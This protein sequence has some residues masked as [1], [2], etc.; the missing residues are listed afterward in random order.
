MAAAG[1][2]STTR[3]AAWS[4]LRK[5]VAA[6]GV[7]RWHRPGSDR[8]APARATE[9]ASCPVVALGCSIQAKVRPWAKALGVNLRGR[10]IRLAAAAAASADGKNSRCNTVATRARVAFMGALLLFGGQAIP[11]LPQE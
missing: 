8:E 6:A 4:R 9:G 3:R 7:K 5:K 11:R 2:L 10:L 1:A